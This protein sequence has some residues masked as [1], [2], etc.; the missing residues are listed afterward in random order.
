MTSNI[1]LGLRYATFLKL[2]ISVYILFAPIAIF[3]LS[4]SILFQDYI[5]AIDGTH[6][7]ACVINH[8]ALL[9]L[10]RKKSLTQNVMCVTDFD[11]CFTYVCSG[12]EGGAHNSRI[13]T[14]TIN[15]LEMRFPTSA[16]GTIKS[17]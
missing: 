6:I 11:L 2:L 5:G 1:T 4:S 15:D 8:N 12:W 10:G 3:H 9:F 14:S 13:F 17:F 7:M 16:E